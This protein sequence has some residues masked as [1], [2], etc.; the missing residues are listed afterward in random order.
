MLMVTPPQV[1]LCPPWYCFT[2]P[3]GIHPSSRT[4]DELVFATPSQRAS[5]TRSGIVNW[6]GRF[7]RA[8]SSILMPGARAGVDAGDPAELVQARRSTRER[9]TS[10]DSRQ[11]RLEVSKASMSYQSVL[12][13]TSPSALAAVTA[14]SASRAPCWRAVGVAA[15]VALLRRDRAVVLVAGEARVARGLRPQRDRQQP[16]AV[17]ELGRDPLR[18]QVRLVAAGARGARDVDAHGQ[19]RRAHQ[20]GVHR[21][22]RGGQALVEAV[23]GEVAGRRHVAAGRLRPGR[24]A[25]R[26]GHR[27]GHARHQQAPQAPGRRGSRGEGTGDG[28]FIGAPE[29][30]SGGGASRR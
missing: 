4:Y 5:Q 29:Q 15:A 27:E 12:R 3:P 13:R 18:R 11:W 21:L 10:A 22:L 16:P 30:I 14:L 2:R 24:Y 28:G 8:L 17:R 9:K 7:T 26:R 23:A 25:E 20:P 1:S 6:S 19:E